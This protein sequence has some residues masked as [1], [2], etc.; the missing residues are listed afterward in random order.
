MGKEIK[1][2]MEV[3]SRCSGYFRPVGQ[4]N[5]GKREE[6]SQRRKM[7]FNLAPEDRSE[8]KV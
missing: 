4:W 3:Y 6:F 1:V 8:I 7:V 5:A 2:P